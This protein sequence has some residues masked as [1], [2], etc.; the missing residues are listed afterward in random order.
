[1]R[2]GLVDLDENEYEIIRHRLWADWR[3]ENS[4]RKNVYYAIIFLIQKSGRSM[5]F[6]DEIMWNARRYCPETEIPDCEKCIFTGVCRKKIELFQP[7][8][9]TTNY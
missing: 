4:I 2:L 1:M 5:S 9:R 8:Y 3:M 7:V 6:I